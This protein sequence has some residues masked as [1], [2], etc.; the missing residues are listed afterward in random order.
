MTRALRLGIT[1]FPT[2]GGSGVIA[3]EIG[4][5]MAARGHRVHFIARDVPVRLR[6]ALHAGVFF[7]E[8]MEAEHPVLDQA[9]SYPIALA[10]KMIDVA[11]HEPLDVLHV[12]YAVPH[13]TAAWMACQ[14]LGA[15]APRVV[16]TL[17]GTDITLVGKDPSFLPIT[18]F[19]IQQSDAVTTPSQSL[20]Q[21]TYDGLGI[22]RSM[23]IQV[24]H[25]FVDT[26]R[27]APHADR[28]VLQRVFPDLAAHEKVLFHAS[29]FRPVK[30]VLDVVAIHAAVNARVAAR[31]VLVGDGPERSRAER[32]VRESGLQGRVVFLGKQESFE[33]LLANADVFLLPSTHESFGLA[34]L[35]AMACGV[36]VVAS[37]V[38]GIPEVVEHGVTG[39]LAPVG[40]VQAMAA[41]VCVLLGDEALRKR[42]S[43]A[44]RQHVLQ[45][46]QPGPAVDQYEA[47]YRQVLARPRR[48]R[49]QGEQ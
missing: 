46:H 33:A 8:V 9:G 1:C 19:S 20:K 24:I 44:A 26:Q 34:A 47:L 21:E 2:F 22:P 4:L 16:T 45:Q 15:R 29:N 27:F 36:P 42:F 25:N 11:T 40:D 28:A 18:R 32:V 13:A 41:H 3:A 23:P 5:A 10:S 30:R 49:A 31:L 7:H 39:W 48:E 43:V 17:H 14:V 6:G 35:E 38:G 37:R 12:H